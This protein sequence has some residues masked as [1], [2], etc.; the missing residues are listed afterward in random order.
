MSGKSIFKKHAQPSGQKLSLINVLFQKFM[1]HVV[2]IM[3]IFLLFSIA[4]KKQVK[5][6]QPVNQFSNTIKIIPENQG[7]NDEIKLVVYDDCTYNTLSKNKRN[8]KTIEIE[9]QFNSMMKLPCMMRNDTILIGKLPPG[10]Y[11]VNYRL[12]DIS[13]QTLQNIALSFKFQLEVTK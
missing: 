6:D 11:N 1:K 4:C 12:I 5:E 3:T 9:K 7:S 13:Q 10:T 2:Y 8:G